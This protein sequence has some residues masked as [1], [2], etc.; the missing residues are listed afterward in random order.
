MIGIKMTAPTKVNFRLDSGDAA[1]QMVT[2]G[3]IIF[4]HKLIIKPV[5]ARNTNA[6]V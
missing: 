4:G 2:D 5:K 3:G 6:S 1:C